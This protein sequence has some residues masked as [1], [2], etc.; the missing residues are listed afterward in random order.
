MMGELTEMKCTARWGDGADA[1]DPEI[2]QPRLRSRR[3][4][5]GA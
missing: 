1:D 4:R 3:A 5:P 2:E